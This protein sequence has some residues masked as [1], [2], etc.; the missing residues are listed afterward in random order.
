[1]EERYKSLIAMNAEPWIDHFRKKAGHTSLWTSKPMAIVIKPSNKNKNTEDTGAGENLPLTVVSPVEQS[2][3]IA[4]AELASK[5]N[6]RTFTDT[7]GSVHSPRKPQTQRV[8]RKK[9]A[10]S[11][12]TSKKIN[13]IK[14]IFTQHVK[15]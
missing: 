2:N 10:P 5:S 3:E 15:R 7:T 8:K 12:G 1:M 11:G 9:T 13:R 4:Q 14:D 6:K